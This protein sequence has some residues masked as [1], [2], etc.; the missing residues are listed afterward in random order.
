MAKSNTFKDFI[1]QKEL[2]RGSF[3]V[4]YLVQQTTTKEL[5]V[6]KR[7]N[8]G[9]LHIKYQQAALREVEILK[10][11]NH[12]N[13]IKY[14]FSYIEDNIL[15]IFMEYAEAGD[16]YQL[17]LKHRHRKTNITEK[18]LWR[19]FI[20][21]SQAV[22]YLHENKIIHRDIKCQNVFLTKN[23]TVK[24]GDLGASKLMTA[25]MQVTRVGTPLYLA[26]EM[27]K[28]QPYDFKID[29]WGLGCLMYTLATHESPFIGSNLITLGISI[30]NRT[31]K[32]LPMIYS[33]KLNKLILLLLEKNP[34]ERPDIGEVLKMALN[35]ADYDDTPGKE[36]NFSSKKNLDDEVPATKFMRLPR[37][38]P[39]PSIAS[40]S[41]PFKPIIREKISKRFPK[42][43][44][45]PI[46]ISMLQDDRPKTDRQM[47][48]SSKE[49]IRKCVLEEFKSVNEEVPSTLIETRPQ[50]AT[51][52]AEK[53][54]SRPVTAKP[55]LRT[56]IRSTTMVK[57]NNFVPPTKI[58]SKM[59]VTINE[60]MHYK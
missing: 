21:L 13:V 56:I 20:E 3:G 44:I 8:I 4:V 26:P 51:D 29:I 30:I 59:K 60:I 1:I 39:L 27:I 47:R 33:K 6:L 37:P 2:G 57:I 45:S 12:P 17:L 23:F 18:E 31:P 41:V 16:L 25:N 50:T 35:K 5:Y 22:N 55:S 52:K 9:H 46:K 14:Y 7:I 43:E 53:A 11:I 10:T 42:L 19:I 48:I 32:N 36:F 49:L 28:Q 38:K 40:N 58:A 24:L 54:F 34:E 15:S